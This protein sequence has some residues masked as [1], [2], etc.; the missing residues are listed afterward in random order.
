MMQHF[1]YICCMTATCRGNHSV[2]APPTAFRFR[3]RWRAGSNPVN[4]IRRPFVRHFRN[5]ASREMD[6]TAGMQEGI[7]CTEQLPGKFKYRGAQC[8]RERP[9]LPPLRASSRHGPAS[10]STGSRSHLLPASRDV[11]PSMDAKKRG[12]KAPFSALI[13]TADQNLCFMPMVQL[14]KFD[15]VIASSSLL[16]NPP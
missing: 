7:Q 11:R 8:V 10:L 12:P 6:T 14:S 1:F 13:D 9:Y 4:S 2:S 15:P 3:C 16:V 5:S